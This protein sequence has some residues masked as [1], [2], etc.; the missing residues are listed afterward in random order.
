MLVLLG[1]HPGLELLDTAHGQGGEAARKYKFQLLTCAL[2]A[3]RL[4]GTPVRRAGIVF[5][6]GEP[7]EPARL[8][9]ESQALAG[10]EA[11]AVAL[12]HRIAGLEQEARDSE[13]WP[14]IA[15]PNCEKRRCGF[16]ARCHGSR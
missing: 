11:R 5:F 14:R 2:A 12:M 7:A 16:I 15:R 8:D 6:L 10:L 3:G 13:G 9:L 1:L 4:A